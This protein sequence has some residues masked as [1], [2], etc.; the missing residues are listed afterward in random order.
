MPHQELL[1]E[2][3][4]YPK[5]WDHN[6]EQRKNDS[7]KVLIATIAEIKIKDNVIEKASALVTTSHC[8]G[9]VLN[10]FASIIKNT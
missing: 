8:G 2:L 3:V 4:G 1:F 7:K 6:R 9:K 5:L 10:T